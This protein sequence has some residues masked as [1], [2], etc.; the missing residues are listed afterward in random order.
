ME[1]KAKQG[2][3]KKFRERVS[4]DRICDANWETPDQLAASVVLSIRNWE[5]EHPHRLQSPEK[6]ISAQPCP[7]RQAEALHHYLESL[8]RACNALP[9]AAISEEADPHRRAEIT[10]N[11]VYVGK[12]D[13]TTQ[14]PLTLKTR[15]ARTTERGLRAGA[16]RADPW[17]LWKLRLLIGNW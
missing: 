16:A 11:R 7:D 14:V 2:K 17:G 6:P 5:L 12:L 3:Q 13:T 8:R 1:S 15:D 4:Q 9:L 10:L